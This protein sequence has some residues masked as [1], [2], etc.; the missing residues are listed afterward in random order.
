MLFRHN[1]IDKV[2]K[3]CT[4]VKNVLLFG[5]GIC[6]YSLRVKLVKL[7]ELKCHDFLPFWTNPTN[8]MQS[9]L[10]WQSMEKH[11]F[12]E[13]LPKIIHQSKLQ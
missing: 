11:E 1:V 3:L 12:H 10:K 7:Q 6:Q 4:N 13:V 5:V 8:I 9:L 2:L